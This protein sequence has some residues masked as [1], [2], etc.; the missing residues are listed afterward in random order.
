MSTFELMAMIGAVLVWCVVGYFVIRRLLLGTPP[1]RP[2]P[3]EHD[4]F[5]PTSS[6]NWVAWLESGGQDERPRPSGEDD[7]TKP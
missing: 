5:S 6:R 4:V 2:R 3:D 1:P 7:Q